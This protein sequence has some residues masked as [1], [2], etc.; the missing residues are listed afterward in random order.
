MIVYVFVLLFILAG[1]CGC[2]E[3]CEGVDTCR[4]TDKCACQCEC[5]TCSREY[6]NKKPVGLLL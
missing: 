3:G 2:G 4:C 6:R 5:K 1:K